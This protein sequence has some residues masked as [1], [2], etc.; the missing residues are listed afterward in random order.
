MRILTPIK[1]NV[2][3]SFAACVSRVIK[4]SKSGQLSGAKFPSKL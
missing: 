2:S 3:L 1:S 4:K